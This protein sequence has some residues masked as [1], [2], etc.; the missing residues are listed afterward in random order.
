[1]SSVSQGKTKPRL[2]DLLE[3]H[4][5]TTTLKRDG[6]FNSQVERA[7]MTASRLLLILNQDISCP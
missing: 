6:N 2:N 5:A 7:T 4:I 1:M 3:N